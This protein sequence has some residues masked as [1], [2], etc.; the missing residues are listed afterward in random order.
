MRSSGVRRVSSAVHQHPALAR[1][2]QAHQQLEQGGLA[3]AVAP[4]QRHDLARA[5]LQAR[6][7]AAPRAHRRCNQT[8]ST[9]RS[10]PAGCVASGRVQPPARRSGAASAPNRGSALRRRRA[11]LMLRGS[12]LPAQRARH[13]GQRRRQRHLGQHRRA[14]APPRGAGRRPPAAGRRCGPRAAR[15]APAGARTARSSGPRSLFSLTSVSSTSSAACGSSCEVG[16]SSTRM[17]GCRVSTAPMATRWRSPPD[18]LLS[19]RPAQ[20]RRWKLVQHFLDALAH[21]RGRQAGVLHGKGQFVLHRVGHHLRFGV[22]ED[23]ADDSRSWPPAPRPSG[24]ARPPAP[25]RRCA[26]R[27]SAAP[28]RSARAAA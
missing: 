18:R 20:R 24:L 19:R 11:S 28:A 23:H 16:S 4:H 12:G 14:A 3:R 13:R 15:R 17:R 6:S 1:L 2:E 21:Q 10:M 9:R 25:A 8:F 5:R 26:R 22:L 7:R 27:R